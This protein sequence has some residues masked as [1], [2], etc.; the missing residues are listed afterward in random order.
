MTVRLLLAGAILLVAGH[1]ALAQGLIDPTR[2]SGMAQSAGPD[3]GEAGAAPATQLQSVLIASGR[4]VAVIN[5]TRVMQG[6]MYGDA[7][8]VKISESEVVLR[9]GTETE[10]L[11]M[12]PGIEKQPT[13]R[14]F[15][16][17]GEKK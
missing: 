15:A 13:K 7:K 14:R 3:T 11:K 17:Q 4:R 8:V 5:G 10:V 6:D 2:P 16:R 1:G 9:K 12:Y